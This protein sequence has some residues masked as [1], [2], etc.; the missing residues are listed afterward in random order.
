MR[1]SP[2]WER[3]CGGSRQPDAMELLI[4]PPPD[5]AELLRQ[6]L[7]AIVPKPNAPR[8]TASTPAACGEFTSLLSEYTQHGAAE[9]GGITMRGSMTE[10]TLATVC[11]LGS[12]PL[13]EFNP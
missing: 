10:N 8:L 4:L 11:Y 2:G 6:V 7:L 5:E 1:G 12:S 9:D 13:P 3:D